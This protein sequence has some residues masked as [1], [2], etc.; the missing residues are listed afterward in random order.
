M[1]R[2][3]RSLREYQLSPPKCNPDSNAKWLLKNRTWIC[4]LKR[5]LNG[6]AIVGNAGFSSIQKNVSTYTVQNDKTPKRRSKIIGSE[7]QGNSMKESLILKSSDKSLSGV[8]QSFTSNKVNMLFLTWKPHKNLTV[9]SQYLIKISA[10]A[11]NSSTS[12]LSSS[13][14]ENFWLLTFWT[15]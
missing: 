14:L 8:V 13:F 4:A 9:H 1:G 7:G 12:C 10:E 2:R 3:T 15:L 5:T 11:K 6:K